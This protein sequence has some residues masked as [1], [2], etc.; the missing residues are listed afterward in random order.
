[1]TKYVIK[2]SINGMTADSR[3]VE[4]DSLFIAYPGHQSDGREYIADAINNGAGA[5]IWDNRGFTWNPSWTVRNIPIPELKLQAGYIASQFYNSPSEKMW[6]VGVTGTNGKTT[7]T[8]WLAQAY[9]ILQKKSAVIGTLGNGVLK[10]LQ[11]AKNTTPGPVELQKM[12]AEFLADGVEAVAM[13]VSS[14][15]LDQGRVNGVSFDV[16]VF[17]NISRDHLDYHQTME[18]YQEAK[19]QLFQWKTLS[20]CVINQDDAFG[21]ELAQ[22]LTTSGKR[23]LTY[24]IEGGDVRVTDLSVR[25]DGFDVSVVT[26]AGKGVFTLNAL[27]QFN[28]SNALA[29]LATMLESK[30]PLA[31]ALAVIGNLKSVNG[32]MQM[33]GGGDQPLVV[34]DYAHTPDALEKVLKTLKAQTKSRLVCVFGCG[35]DRDQ[36]KRPLMGKLASDF[37]DFVVV[38]NDNPRNE[39][40]EK[41]IE[42]IVDAIETSFV[43]EQDRAQ[44][45]QTAIQS[46]GVGDVVL[47][48]GKGHE[49]Y[50]DAAGKKT[51]FS[52]AQCVQQILNH[53]KA[54]A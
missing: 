41:I 32:R 39:A 42:A 8:H 40:P 13:E 26:P 51:F 30:V 15:G 10:A 7:V 43:I 45:I 46:A 35:G 31:Q 21:R 47:V 1:M 27:G 49:E 36:G 37:S 9:A 54:V 19:R 4:K 3:L 29:V 22:S 2:A 12:L 33:F 34:V 16:A 6:C 50:Q 11:E 52:D 28:V 23:V 25:D 44:A 24:G 38:T 14:H 17:T 48:A 53:L 5:I 20:S 18:A